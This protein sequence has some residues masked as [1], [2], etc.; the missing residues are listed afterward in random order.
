[1]PHHDWPGPLGWPVVIGW[2]LL[3]LAYVL[4]MLDATRLRQ[5]LPERL[6]HIHAS[7]SPGPGRA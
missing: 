7:P 5:K 1:V 3:G 2:F 4:A 6:V